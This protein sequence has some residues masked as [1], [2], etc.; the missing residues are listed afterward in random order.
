MWQKCNKGTAIIPTYNR[1]H[2]IKKCLFSLQNQ[3]QPFHQIIIVD[4]SDTPLITDKTFQ[5]VLSGERFNGAELVYLHTKKGLPFQRNRGIE[6][7]TGDIIYFFDDDAHIAQNYLEIM[8]KTFQEHPNY[9]GGMGVIANMPA[10][11]KRRTLFTKPFLLGRYGERYGRFTASGLPIFSYNAQTFTTVGVLNGC[12]AYRKEVLDEF[13][14]DEKLGGYAFMEDCDMSK[15]VS[16]KHKLFFQ[17]A[18]KLY[19]EPSPSARMQ[20][21]KLFDMYM[22]NYCYL[23]YKNFYQENRWRLFAHIWSIIGLHF[24][25]LRARSWRQFVGYMRGVMR[26]YFW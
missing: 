18:A 4:S 16:R 26:Y 11:Y 19:H 15:R 17:P 8:T 12:A 23:F 21:V 20:P 24:Q 5:D 7:A 3:S 22:Y 9:G 14:F 13:C 1:P 25:A 10:S 2:D 6:R